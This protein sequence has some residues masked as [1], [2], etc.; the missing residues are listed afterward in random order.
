VE[1]GSYPGWIRGRGTVL[2]EAYD[3][4]EGTVLSTLDEVEGY[5][6]G[7][8]KDSLYLRR[9]VPIE[10][11]STGERVE[12]QTYLYNR[13]ADHLPRIVSGDYRAHILDQKAGPVEYLAFGSNLSMERL[14]RR[15]GG[16]NR[17][18]RGSL[19]GFRLTYNKRAR[20]VGLHA[21][22]NIIAAVQGLDCPCVAYEM[23]R[24]LLLK[25]DRYEGVPRHYLRT[26]FPMR[27]ES[28][29]DVM[30]YIYVAHPRMLVRGA[31]PSR[32]YRSHLLQGYRDHQLGDLEDYEE[33]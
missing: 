29:E 5:D 2:G 8:E 13:R 15:V 19:P 12:A 32:S 9:P 21:Y 24:R 20:G 17:S 30:G 1:A 11:L 33:F 4:G 22:A 14:R 28:G 23:D 27:C 6:P 18:R 3:A 7:G 16:W 31:R 10:L 26:A 25:L